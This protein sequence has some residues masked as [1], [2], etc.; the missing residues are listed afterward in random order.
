MRWY[1][2]NFVWLIERNLNFNIHSSL[3]PK[4]LSITTFNHPYANIILPSNHTYKSPPLPSHTISTFS[5][6][7]SLK[8]PM[9]AT[10]PNS[11]NS[12][13]PPVLATGFNNRYIPQHPRNPIHRS[14]G[15]K[16]FRSLFVGGNFSRIRNVFWKTI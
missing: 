4:I 16:K 1:L 9:D 6:I 10:V 8:T 11:N 15:T 7:P 13:N 3:T 12:N 14:H 5:F 2:N